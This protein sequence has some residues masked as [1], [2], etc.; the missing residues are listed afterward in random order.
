MLNINS[1][2]NNNKTV[3]IKLVLITLT[4]GFFDAAGIFAIIPYVDVMFGQADNHSYFISE[5]LV[6]FPAFQDKIYITLFFL[7]FYLVR[8]LVLATLIHKTQ[9]IFASANAKLLSNL[10]QFCF[11]SDVYSKEQSSKLIRIH[12][13][14][15]LVF[16]YAF[17]IQASVLISELLIFIFLFIGIVYYQPE[18]ILIFPIIVL[19]VSLGYFLI[20]KRVSIWSK[21]VQTY[22]SRMIKHIQEAHKAHDE[23][24]VY[25]SFLGFKERIENVFIRKTLAYSKTESLMQ[26]PRIMLET[27]LVVLVVLAIYYV[28]QIHSGVIQQ[29]V[30]IF[31]ILAGFRFLPM[32]NRITQSLGWFRNG[33]VALD[34]LNRVYKHPK[35]NFK[36]NISENHSNFEVDRAAVMLKNVV[37]NI[38][39]KEEINKLHSF[40]VDY[41][42]LT[43]ITGETGSGKSTL[44][45]QIAGVMD[46]QGQIIFKSCIQGSK[47]GPILSYVPQSP[48]IINDSVKSNI[49]FF[50]NVIN[51]L[52]ALNETLSVVK[53]NKRVLNS[54][55]GIDTVLSESGSNLSGGEKY[56]V[57]LARALL[58]K[59]NILIMDEP[60]SSLDKKTSI[61]VIQ[62]I[63]HFLPDAA[64]IISSHDQDII[65]LSNKVIEL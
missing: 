12:T 19:L 41:G 37:S 7:S 10:F 24:T 16:L 11:D 65:N 1:Y 50:R 64:I 31:I 62:N 53:L 43:C 55:N 54:D 13:R 18:A 34:E 22:D 56:R 14:D 46:I 57:C 61:E 4:I 36:I 28:T 9:M 27:I 47:K 52:E 20:K 51:D 8:A 30:A 48:S 5:L 49:I 3:V 38:F 35:R 6:L 44:L 25:Q 63:K 40:D 2:Y 42:E 17:L 58:N 39:E 60:T 26:M 15:S 29:S 45:K 21:E 59:P 33:L 32:A 23:I